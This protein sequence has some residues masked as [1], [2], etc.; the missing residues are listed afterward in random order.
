MSGPARRPASLART[1]AVVLA[2]PVVATLVHALL[3]AP[4][5]RGSDD[6]VFVAVYCAQVV[7]WMAL[8]TWLLTHMENT[9]RQAVVAV[10]LGWVVALAAASVVAMLVLVAL[11]SGERCFS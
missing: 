3:V 5:M 1:V 11:C 9:T 4:P 7:L 10:V 6:T 2:V 8:T